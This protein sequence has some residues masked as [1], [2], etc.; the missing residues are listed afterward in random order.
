LPALPALALAL[1]WRLDALLP[2]AASWGELWRCRSRLALVGAVLVLVG[3]VGAAAAAALGRFIPVQ[4]GALLA[5]AA[6]V[7]LL[8]VAWRGGASWAVCAA[9]TFVVLGG[10]VIELLPAYNRHFALRQE[11][12]GLDAAAA[13]RIVCYPQR[14]DSV[15]F[16]LP[17]STVQ[18]Y[19]VADRQRLLRDLEEHPETP[20]VIKSGRALREVLDDLPAA[21]E[22]VTSGE[23]EAVTLGR[24]RR[25][26]VVAGSR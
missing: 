10:G 19:A 6:C 1:G 8:W 25:R 13:A 7:G 22:L 24:L 20:L 4:T 18:A 21:W 12:R 9:A 2:K 23:P 3:G 14:W 26:N 15:S 17:A 5:S 11:L 16:Y